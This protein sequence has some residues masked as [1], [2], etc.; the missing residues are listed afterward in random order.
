[1][2]G[3]TPRQLYPIGEVYHRSIAVRQ[4]SQGKDT[5]LTYQIQPPPPYPFHRAKLVIHALPL[6]WE[7]PSERTRWYALSVIARFQKGVRPLL[8]NSLAQNW[9]YWPLVNFHSC[10]RYPTC[11]TS[12]PDATVTW[13]HSR[14]PILGLVFLIHAH[15]RA[16]LSSRSLP[17]LLWLRPLE[18]WNQIP[19][20]RDR[21]Q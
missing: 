16:A 15:Q 8:L 4:P 19:S 3:Q 6:V 21:Y 9:L 18:S 14:L 7:A 2:D 11:I 10:G 12:W 13:R 1:M 17:R 5:D 20:I